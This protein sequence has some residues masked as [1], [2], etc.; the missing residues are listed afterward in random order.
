M[1][2]GTFNVKCSVSDMTSLFSLF[3][4]QLMKLIYVNLAKKM[5]TVVVYVSQQFRREMSGERL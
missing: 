2:H 1:F 4:L 3:Y 5:F